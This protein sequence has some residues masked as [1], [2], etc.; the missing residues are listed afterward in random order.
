MNI[1][2]IIYLMQLKTRVK[3]SNVK[4]QTKNSK[5]DFT[6]NTATAT[7]LCHKQCLDFSR[8]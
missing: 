6:T 5:T 8:Q 3:R 7:S 2:E 1:I 4:C